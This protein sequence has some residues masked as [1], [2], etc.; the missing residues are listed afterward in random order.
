MKPRTLSAAKLRIGMSVKLAD[1]TEA[2][3]RY[4]S[5][6]KGEIHGLGGTRELPDEVWLRFEC[7]RWLEMLSTDRMEVCDERDE[8]GMAAPSRP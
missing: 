1:G 5:T 7:G 4:R 6:V 3:I 8:Q 2:K